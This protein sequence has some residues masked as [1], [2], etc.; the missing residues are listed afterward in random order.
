MNKEQQELIDQAPPTESV[1]DFLRTSPDQLG[2]I[3]AEL[4]LDGR[5]VA[6]EI[7]LARGARRLVDI[8]NA[9]EGGYL[10][11]HK[12]TLRDGF[13][14][15][16]EFDLIQL[17]RS[18][19]LL[20]FP[21]Q[22]SA[23]RINPGEV[24]K[25]HRRLVTV[26]MPGCQVSGY[27]HAALGVDPSVVTTTASIGNRFV[28][29]TDA[30]ITVIDGDMPTRFESVALLNTAHV[31]AYVWSDEA[32]SLPPLSGDAEALPADELTEPADSPLA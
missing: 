32:K 21:H 15:C 2:V 18:S 30:T 31:Q 12:G 4:L 6:G 17:T 1:P 27:F 25:K 29:L 24:I 11:M 16:L 3:E 26:I 23:S 14:S 9:L 13:G 5:Q 10:T 7:W 28:A 22:G 20:A 19:I 8:L